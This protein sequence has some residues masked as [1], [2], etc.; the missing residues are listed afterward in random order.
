MSNSNL[1]MDSKITRQSK[2]GSMRSAVPKAGTAE[3]QAGATLH[4][5][6]AFLSLFQQSKTAALPDIVIVSV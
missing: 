4:K 5:T 6:I 1:T 3:L 2:T